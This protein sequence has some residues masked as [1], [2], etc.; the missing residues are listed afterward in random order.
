LPTTSK[1]AVVAEIKEK[2]TAASGV[3][4][5]DYR[6]LTVKEMQALRAKLRSAGAEIKVYKNSLTELAIRE[7]SLPEMDEMLAGPTA[8]TFTAGDAV[9][10]AKAMMDF[11]KDHK[12]LEIKGG[13]IENRL[14]NAASVKV[15]ASLP[16]HEQL[17]ASLLATMNSPMS[18]LVRVLSGPA[19]AFARTVRAIA[20]QKAAAA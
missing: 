8:F 5:S 10:P 11:S 1:A 19:A 17:V 2:L 13:F 20:D 14:V 7:L 18:G 15:L 6:G 12:A 3:I 16:S 9:V 4:L